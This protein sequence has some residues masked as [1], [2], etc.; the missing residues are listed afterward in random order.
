MRSK[1]VC[2]SACIALAMTTAGNLHAQEAGVANQGA[3]EVAL[4]PVV[5]ASPKQRIAQKPRLKPKGA[6]AAQS[7][8][9]SGEAEKVDA[10]GGEGDSGQRCRQARLNAEPP[11]QHEP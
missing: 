7:G 10:K 11:D 9:T 5:V 8:T 3:S 6:D 2:A 4:P 1:N